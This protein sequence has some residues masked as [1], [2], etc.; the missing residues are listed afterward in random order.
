MAATIDTSWAYNRVIVVTDKGDV[1][2]TTIAGYASERVGDQLFNAA[3]N[4]VGTMFVTHL[5]GNGQRDWD[6]RATWSRN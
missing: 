4:D 5:V 3:K 2:S 1:Q 6:P